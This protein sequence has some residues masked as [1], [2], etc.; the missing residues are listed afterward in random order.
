MASKN[1]VNS[2]KKDKRLKVSLVLCGG[3]ARGY[4]HIGVIEELKKYDFEIVS[5]AGTS[6]GAVVGALEACGKLE[7]YKKWV[8]SLDFI[9]IFKFLKTPF[10]LDGDKIFKK[11][12]ELV[13]N[14]KIEDLPIKFTAVATDLTKGKEVWIQ[15]GNVWEAVKA[16]SAI[17]GVFD[18]VVI[19]GRMLVDGGVLNLMPVAPVMSDFSDL[20]IAVNLF[21]EENNKQYEIP[22]E[23]KK[24]QSIFEDI[25]NK[26]FQEKEDPVNKSIDL[27]MSTIF[28]YRRAEY[29]P[30]LE[31][32]IPQNIAQWYEFHRAPELIEIG[33]LIAKD[34]L[35]EAKKKGII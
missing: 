18:P 35:G 3:G 31:I 2:N 30:D 9:D 4:T 20:I 1:T 29:K 19:N 6:M 25:W 34:A 21:G 13:G 33:K 14:Y 28:R 23:I 22:H 7:V 5:I 12:V 32:F 15:R 17:P 26:I 8:T 16:S 10:K 24:K 27:M 11:I